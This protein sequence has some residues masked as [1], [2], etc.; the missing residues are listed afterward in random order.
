MAD[1]SQAPRVGP[2]YKLSL[3]HTHYVHDHTCIWLCGCF[4]PCR[5]RPVIPM[6]FSRYTVFL[7][8][9]LCRV[10][11]PLFVL[12]AF[13]FYNAVGLASCCSPLACLGFFP[14]TL[15]IISH[16][17]PNVKK[18]FSGF[19]SAHALGQL[20]TSRRNGCQIVGSV[21]AVLLDAVLCD[22][23]KVL[24][25]CPLDTLNCST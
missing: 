3:C 16:W 23:S 18:K 7:R 17:A 22:I 6:I 11:K 25:G 15:W 9:T 20:C 14:L 2:G 24:R 8:P 12:S 5:T 21:A 13:S 10:V 19:P 1:A 4:V